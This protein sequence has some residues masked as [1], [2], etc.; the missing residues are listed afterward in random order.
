RITGLLNE[1]ICRV[2]AGNYHT[3]F[4]NNCGQ[5]FAA[6]Y[7]NHGQL[8]V[9]IDKCILNTPVLIESLVRENMK[10]GAALCG[11]C[12]TIF[13]EEGQFENSLFT[14]SYMEKSVSLCDIRFIIE[15]SEK[16][17]TPNVRKRK[18]EE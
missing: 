8:G 2:S 6:G 4:L 12:R 9:A 5:V 15:D 18:I 17:C 7:N 10:V 3:M 1:T 16:T 13:L 11:S 14:S